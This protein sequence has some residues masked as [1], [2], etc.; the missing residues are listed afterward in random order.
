MDS[1]LVLMLA[2][3]VGMARGALSLIFEHPLDTLKTYWQAHPSRPSLN[4]VYNE[5]Y[6]LKGWRGFYSGAVPNVLRVMF[7]QSYRYPLMVVVPGVYSNVFHSLV[8]ISMFTGLTIAV[9]EVFLITPLERLKVW[10]MTFPKTAGGGRAF[11][12][13]MKHHTFAVLYKGLGITALRQIM[14]WVTFLV[15]HDQLIWSARH[16]LG[17][18]VLSLGMLLLISLVEG[19]INTVVILPID[20]VKTNLQKI[21]SSNARTILGVVR[22]IYSRYGIK[23]FYTGW[24][25]RLIQYMIHSGFTVSLLEKLRG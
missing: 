6:R 25:L 8:L 10:L 18:H 9:I 16:T 23:G 1:Y 20:A 24:S 5:I 7:K 11:L 14:S 17:A 13:A 4:V 21:N 22:Y 19:G 2:A 3:G 12:N 15:V